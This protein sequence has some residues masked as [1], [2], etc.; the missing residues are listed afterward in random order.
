M[1]LWIRQRTHVFLAPA[2]SG[3]LSID[4]LMVVSGGIL[5]EFTA[6]PGHLYVVQYSDDNLLWM[7]SQVRI[8]AAGNRVQWIDQ[9]APRTGSSPFSTSHRFYRVKEVPEL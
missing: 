2:G 7:D 6:I 5:L 8:R 9:G 3:G 4:R 1:R